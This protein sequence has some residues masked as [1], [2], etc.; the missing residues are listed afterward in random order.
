ML[1]GKEALRVVSTIRTTGGRLINS[2]IRF[3]GFGFGFGFGQRIKR[4]R[5]RSRSK[6]NCQLGFASS[7]LARAFHSQRPECD[8]LAMD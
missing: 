7:N 6:T 8:H 3:I 5:R 2:H 4:E 1:P